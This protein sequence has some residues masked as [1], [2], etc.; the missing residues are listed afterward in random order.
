MSPAECPFKTITDILDTLRKEEKPTHILVDFHAE[1]TSEKMAMGWYLDGRVSGVFGTHTHIQTND[2]RLLNKGTVYITDIGMTG[3]RDSVL[4]VDKDIIIKKM[5]NQM[6]VKFELARG[7]LQFN[8]IV[9][10]LDA[11][12]KAKE[13]KTLNFFEPAL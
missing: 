2:A 7:D 5:L 8:G 11:P 6:P 10:D 12:L 13:I 9:L 4:G 3:P 1:A